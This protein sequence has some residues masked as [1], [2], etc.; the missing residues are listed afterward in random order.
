MKDTFIFPL[1]VVMQ[2]Q[3]RDPRGL[4]NCLPNLTKRP[5]ILIPLLEAAQRFDLTIIKHS[6]LIDNDQRKIYL[7][8]KNNFWV[9]ITRVGSKTVH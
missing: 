1:Q 8:V 5:D 6:S 7:K 2:S 4:L 3:S 9:V